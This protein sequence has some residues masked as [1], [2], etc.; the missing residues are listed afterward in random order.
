MVSGFYERD[1]TGTIT[2][3]E[4]FS[5]QRDF[6]R[7]VEQNLYVGLHKQAG[8]EINMVRC[9]NH[10]AFDDLGKFRLIDEESLGNEFRYY[11][12]M[13]EDLK[14]CRSE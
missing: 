11:I 13:M 1:V 14:N 2:E 9:I 4:M 3:K 6:F 5:V 12:R 8:G 10:L 7:K